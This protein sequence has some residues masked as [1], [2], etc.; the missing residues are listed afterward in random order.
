MANALVNRRTFAPGKTPTEF[1]RSQSA[2]RPAGPVDLRASNQDYIARIM[3]QFGREPLEPVV[4]P[5]SD[6]KAFA[7]LDR[8]IARRLR[9]GEEAEAAIQWGAASRWTIK[10]NVAPEQPSRTGVNII[11][12]DPDPPEDVPDPVSELVYTEQWREVHVVRV[13]NPEDA[14]QFV[15]VEVI[16]RIAYLGPDNILRIFVLNNAGA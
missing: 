5:F 7:L 3:R 6:P 16:D 15:D 1:L 4:R 9:P 2:V 10:D 14:E 12:D 8:I 11:D 13:S